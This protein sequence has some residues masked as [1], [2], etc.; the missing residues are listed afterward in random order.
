M[1]HKSVLLVA[2]HSFHGKYSSLHISVALKAPPPI[3][4]TFVAPEIIPN[5]LF[6]PLKVLPPP[7]SDKSYPCQD[8]VAPSQRQ[9]G[10]KEVSVL[11]QGVPGGPGKGGGVKEVYRLDGLGPCL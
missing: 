6:I 10:A 4:I 9:S 2:E 5:L 1:T 8:F 3:I 7:S 11:G